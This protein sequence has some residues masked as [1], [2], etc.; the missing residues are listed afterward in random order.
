MIDRKYRSGDPLA[1]K[2]GYGAIEFISELGARDYVVCGS[3]TDEYPK[4]YSQAAES[5]YFFCQIF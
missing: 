4:N 5:L 2:K 3:L 1:Y